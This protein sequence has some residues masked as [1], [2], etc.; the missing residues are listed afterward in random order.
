MRRL[1]FAIVFGATATLTATMATAAD[2]PTFLDQGWSKEIREL[3]YYTPQGSRIIPYSWFMAIETANGQDMFADTAHLQTYG[4]IP[5]D[6]THAFNPD[7]LPIGFAIDP[8]GPQPGATPAPSADPVD[9]TRV[10]RYLGITC[11]ACH[12]S[13]LSVGGREIRIEGG[14]GNVDF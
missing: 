3:F 4:F 6:G 13:N 14:A 10:G 9:P 11:A 1:G 7:A 2:S 12:T 5:A 8:V